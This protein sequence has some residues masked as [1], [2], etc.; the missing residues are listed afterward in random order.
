MG[1]GK[2]MVQEALRFKLYVNIRL[3][4]GKDT[5]MTSEFVLECS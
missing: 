1:G 4:L 2:F 3:V 5:P